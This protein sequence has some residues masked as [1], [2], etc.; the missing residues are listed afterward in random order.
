MKYDEGKDVVTFI[1]HTMT[2]TQM[3]KISIAQTMQKK[4]NKKKINL[5]QIRAEIE[6]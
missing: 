4:N 1:V 3:I 6:F 5:R 2:P